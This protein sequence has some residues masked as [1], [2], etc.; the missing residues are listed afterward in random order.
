MSKESKTKIRIEFVD[1][2]IE[3]YYDV[4]SVELTDTKYI[5]KFV[6]KSIIY[7]NV[8]NKKSIT[9]SKIDDKAKNTSKCN[10]VHDNKVYCGRFYIGELTGVDLIDHPTLNI[11]KCQNCGAKITSRMTTSCDECGK[12][13][14]WSR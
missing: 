6:D 14:A 1:D 12:I 7:F 8:S 10:H 9:V 2:T 13:I 5:V 3:E 4:E 11:W